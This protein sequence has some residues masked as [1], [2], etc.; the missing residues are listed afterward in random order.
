MFP[1]HPSVTTSKPSPQISTSRL[2]KLEVPLSIRT[3]SLASGS[4][5]STIESPRSNVLRRKQTSVGAASGRQA[6]RI[7]DDSISSQDD[8][9]LMEGI[10]G[11]YKDP[12]S[13]TVLGISL[14]PSSTILARSEG[15]IDSYS[16]PLYDYE[17]WPYRHTSPPNTAVR[18]LCNTL[19][20]ILRFT[21]T[22]QCI[23]HSYVDVVLLAGDNI[24]QS[25]K[26]NSA[27]QSTAEQATTKPSSRNPSPNPASALPT[28]TRA[29][30]RGPTPDF[31]HD[32]KPRRTSTGPAPAPAPAPSPS[33]TSRFGFFT[34]RTKTEPTPV[35]KSESKLHR[36]GPAAGTGH[37]GYG[38]YAVR[39]RSGSSVS[40]NSIGRSASAG[41][42]SESLDKTPSTRKS[43]MTSTTSGEVDDFSSI[44]SLLSLFEVRGLARNSQEAQNQCNLA[45]AWMS[46]SIKDS[47]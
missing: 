39:G 10:P 24:I 37:E 1:Q 3:P 20:S 7:R 9:Q 29:Q 27:S 21:W 15:Q 19:D 14:P 43:S 13:E 34:R 2:P 40:T 33:K 41:T 42:T 12:F 28:A 18:S 11:G 8:R 6:T 46:P 25:L 32:R 45:A 4:S 16:N 30:V 23:I 31:Q 5:A 17:I 35:A 44:A 36:R 26:P 38:R 47:N 22:F